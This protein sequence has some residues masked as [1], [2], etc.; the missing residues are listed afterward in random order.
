MYILEGN[1]LVKSL[2][3][4]PGCAAMFF[5][6]PGHGELHEKH[7][8]VDTLCIVVQDVVR[9]N[10]PKKIP[11]R[12]VRVNVAMYK[13]NATRYLVDLKEILEMWGEW[14]FNWQVRNTTALTCKCRVLND[15][16]N[17]AQRFNKM[18]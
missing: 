8:W 17:F 4:T 12:F 13:M 6:Y 3:S 7:S 10:N 11:A 15:G 14:M 5:E 2:E 1:D 18:I 16:W 9:L